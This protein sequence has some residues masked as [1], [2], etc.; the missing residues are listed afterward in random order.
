M[1]NILA[2]RLEGPSD[3]IRIKLRTCFKFGSNIAFTEMSDTECLVVFKVAHSLWRNL[4]KTLRTV[5]PE[6]TKIIRYEHP[7]DAECYER[8]Y[9]VAQPE[10]DNA[11]NRKKLPP[12]FSVGNPKNSKDYSII[13]DFAKNLSMKLRRPATT[14]EIIAS[15][16]KSYLMKSWGNPAEWNVASTAK[17][18]AERYKPYKPKYTG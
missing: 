2:I 16:N 8:L 18:V 4:V 6:G 13:Y 5:L 11:S 12:S 9:P 1:N 17:V 7:V 15:W 14:E 10:L 3:P